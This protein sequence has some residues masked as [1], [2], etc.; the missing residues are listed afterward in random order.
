[1]AE[2]VD[3]HI[4]LADIS[5]YTRFLKANKVSLRHATQIVSTLLEAVMT[6]AEKPVH[7]NKVEGDAVLFV[8]PKDKGGEDE[9]AWTSIGR[10]FQ[11]FYARRAELQDANSCPCE[12][13]RGIHKLE[14]KVISH[15][16]KLLR[17]RV[18]KF[19]EVSG[20]DLV[21]AHRLM[22][23]QVEGSRYLLS[24][25][26]AWDRYG[27]AIAVDRHVE[28]CEGVGEVPVVVLRDAADLLTQALPPRKVTFVCKLKDWWNKHV[29]LIPILGSWLMARDE[30]HL[31]S[32]C[33]L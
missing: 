32:H 25:E 28:D 30:D 19:E 20:F 11:A 16:G 31:H 26:A 4:L 29:V 15:H 21:I 5:G 6:A 22:K 9:A 18:R 14:L 24:S 17:H 10:F 23:N 13:C 1:M 7:A 3:A 27:S 8:A 2:E 12:A 33:R